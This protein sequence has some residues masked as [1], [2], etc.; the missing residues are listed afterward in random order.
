MTARLAIGKGLAIAALVAILINTLNSVVGLYFLPLS[1]QTVGVLFGLIGVLLSIGTFATSWG[2]KSGMISTLLIIAGAIFAMGA[3]ISTGF[4]TTIVFPGP[5]IGVF[6]GLLV[7]G[8]GISK[9]IKTKTAITANR[10][11]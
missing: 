1:T 4:L 10:A 2:Y 8:L 5:I 6:L 3:L 7:I 9:G 11:L